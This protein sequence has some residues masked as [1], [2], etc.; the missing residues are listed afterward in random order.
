MIIKPSRPQL[1]LT[2][3]V[4]S[5]NKVC[6]VKGQHSDNKLLNNSS[7]ETTVKVVVDI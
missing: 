7:E 5:Q 3:G 1:I 6:G 4:Q 2:A